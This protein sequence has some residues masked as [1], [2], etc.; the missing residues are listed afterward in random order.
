MVFGG[1]GAAAPDSVPPRATEDGSTKMKRISKLCRSRKR[2]ELGRCLSIARHTGE[3]STTT[4]DRASVTAVPGYF[5]GEKRHEASSETDRDVWAEESSK[6]ADH[7]DLFG[8]PQ[9]HDFCAEQQD[10]F[11]VQERQTEANQHDELGDTLKEFFDCI[12]EVKGTVT[13]DMQAVSRELAKHSIGVTSAKS[14]AEL[15]HHVNEIVQLSGP[16]L[17]CAWSTVKVGV[18]VASVLSGNLVVGSFMVALAAGSLGTSLVW[19]AHRDSQRNS[20]TLRKTEGDRKEDTKGTGEGAAAEAS[21]SP[22]R[23]NGNVVRQGHCLSRD[24]FCRQNR[25]RR[26]LIQLRRGGKDSRG[27]SALRGAATEQL[28]EYDAWSGEW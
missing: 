28:I 16:E 10:V 2:G 26:S 19:K 7:E 6:E 14:F 24:P 5:T 25:A 1:R 15:Q 9:V 12:K 17:G 27:D 11:S 18:G 13:E 20:A 22:L 8:F 3:G 4:K 21:V 23:S